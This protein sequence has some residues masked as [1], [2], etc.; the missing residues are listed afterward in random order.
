M[1]YDL[2]KMKVLEGNKVYVCF[3][4]NKEGIV[5]LTKIVNRGGVFDK[6]RDVCF[7]GKAYIDKD[8]ATLAWPGGI[9]IA[10]ETLYEMATC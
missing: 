9:D 2:K 5:D 1:Y 10:P 3:E 4:D 6:L 7:F 8:W